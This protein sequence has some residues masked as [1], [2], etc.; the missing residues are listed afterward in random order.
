[1]AQDMPATS[2]RTSF[3]TKPGLTQQTS[4]VV[5]EFYH[6]GTLPCTY[7]WPLPSKLQSIWWLFTVIVIVQSCPTLCSPKDCSTPGSLSSSVSQ[8]LLKFMSIDSVMLSNL[9]ILCHPTS[10]LAFTLSQLQDFFQWISY[11]HQMAKVL[12]IQ[13]QPQ[14]FR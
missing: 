4:D 10:P 6:V 9:L 1:M 2:S 3:L 12:G 13:L 5:H 14:S 7:V 8:S 11:L